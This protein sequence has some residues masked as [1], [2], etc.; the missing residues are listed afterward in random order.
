[1]PILL[2]LIETFFS[3]ASSSIDSARVIGILLQGHAIYDHNKLFGDTPDNGCPDHDSPL[4][5]KVWKQR[6]ACNWLLVKKNTERRCNIPG[7]ASCCPRTCQRSDFALQIVQSPFTF[8]I[9][10]VQ[11]VEKKLFRK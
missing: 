2:C 5:M 7:V 8:T 1:M 6:R 9:G 11:K 10:L 3:L 4:A